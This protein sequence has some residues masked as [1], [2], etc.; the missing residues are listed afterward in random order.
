MAV[1]KKDTIYVDIDD[2][3]TGIIDKLRNSDGKVVALVLPKRATTFQSIVNMKLLKRAADADNKNL[4]LITSEAGLMPLAGAAGVHVAKTLTSKPEIPAGPDGFEDTEETIDETGEELPDDTAAKAAGAAT[5]GALAGAAAAKK[6]G[7]NDDMETVEL[8]NTDAADAASAAKPKSKSF[9]PPKGGKKGKKD[10]KLKVPDFDKFRLLLIIGAI[11]FVLLIIFGYMAIK[12]WPKAV[13]TLDT[14][15]TSIDTNLDLNLSTTATEL[16]EEEKILP[17]KKVEQ[18]KTYTQEVATT[19]QKNNG[20]KANGTVTFTN[21]SQVDDITLA[22]G[23]GVTSGG[24]TFITQQTVTVPASSFKKGSCQNDGKAS[25]NVI[26]Q[27]PGSASNGANNFSVPGN[28]SLTGSGS[29]SGGTDNIVRVVNQNDINNAQSKINASD[30]GVKSDL[31]DQLKDAD[32]YPLPSTYSTGTP[33]VTSS[34]KVGQVADN[35]TVTQTVTYSMFGVKENDLKKVVNNEIESGIDTNEQ[36]IIDDGISKAT[37]TVAS[38]SSTGAQ[39][40][41]QGKAT[42][43]P[44]LN[45]ASIRKDSLGKKSPQ[46][47]AMFNNNPD[48]TGVDVKLSP[49]WVNSVPNNE[50]KVT[51]K[52]ATPKASNSNSSND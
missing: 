47:K 12:V 38:S 10:S 26:A 19:G 18:Q 13:I 6:A 33:A 48:I 41:M 44:E 37:F 16:N 42:V 7:A 39:V 20:N 40:N 34:A 21:C 8:D 31:E 46:V 23:T 9:A 36:S 49:F 32:Y 22:A 24:N 30:S 15:A 3:I 11:A 29:T 17:A 51:V 14:N 45:I 5:V 28:S 52:I 43:G 1:D 2:E 4:V 25:V 50:K 35:V 27:S